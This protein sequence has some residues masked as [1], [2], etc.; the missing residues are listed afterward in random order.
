MTGMTQDKAARPPSLLP[1]LMHLDWQR[2]CGILLFGCAMG[3]LEAICVVYLRRLIIPAGT[4]PSQALAALGHLPI[5]RI[6]EACTVVML[7]LVAWMTAPS[8]RS[9]TAH[10]F[11]MFGVWDIV[12]YVGLKGF[13][14]WPTA[15]LEWDCLFLLPEP[16]HGP[17]LA[18]I[19][20]SLYLMAA[21]CLL[22]ACES[23]ESTVRVSVPGFALQ[24]PGFLLWY[25]SF[26]KDSD[27]IAAQ[28]YA[29]VNYSWS[30]FAVALVVAVLGL[31]LAARLG[32]RPR[33][34]PTTGAA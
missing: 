20:I 31:W 14:H 19:L 5:E 28:G 29:G 32:R 11:F 27:R 10:F 12:Y 33:R 34:E 7:G 8:W 26:V 2:L 18:P 13:T 24:L 1:A 30:L 25:G 23:A 6:R 21:S 3:L 16:W 22:L 17:V 9:R 15:W 4:D